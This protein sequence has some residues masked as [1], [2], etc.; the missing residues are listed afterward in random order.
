M[1]KK[2]CRKCIAKRQI[3]AP[4]PSELLS[5]CRRKT[6]LKTVLWVNNGG[7]TG[8]PFVRGRVAAPWELTVW[9]P[10]FEF[11]W[12]LKE[13]LQPRRASWEAD[14]SEN[15]SGPALDLGSVSVTWP[16]K[17]ESLIL[18]SRVYAEMLKPSP[19]QVWGHG[20]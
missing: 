15:P 16:L 14:S 3:P 10:Y 19:R 7:D 8:F 4:C 13:A 1:I 6:L 5:W 9:S 12:R 20:E 17:A 18:G 11:V 2:K